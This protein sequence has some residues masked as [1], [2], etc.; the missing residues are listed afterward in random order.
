MGFF[1]KRLAPAFTFVISAV[2][3]H[4]TS[5]TTFGMALNIGQ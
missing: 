4:A 1:E 5:D 2:L 3:D